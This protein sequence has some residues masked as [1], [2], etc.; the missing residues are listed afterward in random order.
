MKHFVVVPGVGTCFI[1][2]VISRASF[3]VILGRGGIIL[4]A[5]RG[6]ER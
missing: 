3:R 2:Q 6:T 4:S 5:A 1:E